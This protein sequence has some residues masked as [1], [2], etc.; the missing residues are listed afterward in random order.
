MQ[1]I[2]SC[3]VCSNPAVK[4]Q[5][6]TVANLLKDG[7]MKT[8]FD[9][10]AHYRIC[11]NPGCAVSYFNNNTIY[12]TQDIKVPLWFKKPKEADVLICYCSGLTRGD[13]INAVRN[14][15]DSLA[16]VRAFTKKTLTGQCLRK[17]PLGKCCH[18]VV[19]NIIKNH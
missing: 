16:A 11:T 4:V 8:G 17:N 3:P 9:D 19:L 7:K 1:M 2:H 14:G 18:E 13:I 6:E 5:V 15:C 10:K 12:D